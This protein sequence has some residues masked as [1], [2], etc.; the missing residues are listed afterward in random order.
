MSVIPTFWSLSW[1][2]PHPN[3]WD[4]LALPVATNLV[5]RP[6]WLECTVKLRHL[7]GSKNLSLPSETLRHPAQWIP[8]GILLRPWQRLQEH[9]SFLL[10]FGVLS[11]FGIHQ[12]T[13][14]IK[15]STWIVF[16]FFF[17]W[18]TTS[19][20]DLARFSSH[21][22]RLF[23]SI[24][25]SIKCGSV[26]K[27]A[28]RKETGLCTGPKWKLW[29]TCCHFSFPNTLLYTLLRSGIEGSR[30][31]LWLLQFQK[32]VSNHL[33]VIS[34]VGWYLEDSCCGVLLAV[35]YV[36]LV[37]RITSF[38]L[39]AVHYLVWKSFGFS[40]VFHLLM[41]ILQEVL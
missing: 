29:S 38:K 34:V 8:L 3:F 24:P 16:Q 40:W 4:I 39:Q 41:C 28:P 36:F 26:F 11:K 30:T 31:S 33:E 10:L 23:E 15:V 2:N 6:F 27:K 35:R 12:V 14:V 22:G 18:R 9:N 1:R 20:L 37:S 7:W 25:F 32:R 5:L 17:A 19:D 21:A 13:I